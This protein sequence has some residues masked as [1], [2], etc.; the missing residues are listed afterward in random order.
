MAG[1]ERKPGASSAGKT[2]I[3]DY[4]NYGF[5]LDPCGSGQLCSLRIAILIE[6]KILLKKEESLGSG[7]PLSKEIN[8]E[9]QT[10]PNPKVYI[11]KGYQ[12]W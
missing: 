4:R 11:R 6:H 9:D 7:T 2:E 12:T 8:Y 3:N 5:S 1:L 10:K